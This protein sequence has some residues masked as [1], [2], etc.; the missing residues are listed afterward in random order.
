[1]SRFVISVDQNETIEPKYFR[2]PAPQPPNLSTN[3]EIR[4][5]SELLLGVPTGLKTQWRHTATKLVSS[6]VR[7]EKV[8]V[9]Y[10][11]T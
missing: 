6:S 10:L 9:I 2:R 4:G 11:E 5:P 7:Y 1:M 8:N 3:L